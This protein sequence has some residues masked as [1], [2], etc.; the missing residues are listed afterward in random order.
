MRQLLGIPEDHLTGYVMAFS[1]PAV[2]YARTVQHRPA[3]INF[4]AG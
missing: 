3:L 2:H 4:F 1:K